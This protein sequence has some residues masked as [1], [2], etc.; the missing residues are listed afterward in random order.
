MHFGGP[1]GCDGGVGRS[2]AHLLGTCHL[3]ILD[4]FRPKGVDIPTAVVDFWLIL[5][6]NIFRLHAVLEICE[7]AFS[8]ITVI[9]IYF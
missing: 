8:P 5:K 7:N 3:H 1:R 2:E 9:N 4:A 6:L